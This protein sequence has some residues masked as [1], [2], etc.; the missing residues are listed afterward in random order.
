VWKNWVKSFSERKKD[1]SPAMRL[2]LTD[3]RLKVEEILKERLFPR[4][5]GLPER[6]ADYYWRRIPT[7]RIPRCSVHQKKFAG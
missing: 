2:G 3:H 5:V 1:G 7:R 4:R 6:W